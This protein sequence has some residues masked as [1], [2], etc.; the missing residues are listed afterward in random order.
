M[1]HLNK[2]QH[3]VL[4]VPAY[5]LCAMDS[6]MTSIG[7]HLDHLIDLAT[8]LTG[9]YPTQQEVD[10]A[11]AKAKE[12]HNTVKEYMELWENADKVLEALIGPFTFEPFSEEEIAKRREAYQNF[13][14]YLKENP[15]A[16]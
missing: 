10:S 12:I 6:D 8:I 5:N 13:K 11:L 4:L 3:Q 16:R 15:E 14:N 1:I 9:G 7:F 2:A